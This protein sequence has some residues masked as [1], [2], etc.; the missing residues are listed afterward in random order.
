MVK[1]ALENI[2]R[3]TFHYFVC[4]QQ[5][6]WRV[7]TKVLVSHIQ[8]YMVKQHHQPLNQVC[9]PWT[10]NRNLYAIKLLLLVLVLRFLLSYVV[11]WIILSEYLK[12]DGNEINV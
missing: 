11:K 6:D 2:D 4:F 5:Y 8:M 1:V 10:Q 3:I 12:I 7:L 9:H